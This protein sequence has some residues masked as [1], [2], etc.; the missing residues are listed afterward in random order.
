MTRGVPKKP[1]REEVD[2]HNVTHLPFRG[3]CETCVAGRGIDSAHRGRD[4]HEVAEEQRTPQVS[5]DWAFLRDST[6]SSLLNVLVGVDKRTRVNITIIAA[7]RTAAN[8]A[9]V[10][11]I[12]SNLRQLGHYGTLIIKTD[13]EPSLVELMTRVA[14]KREAGTILQ[15]SPPYDSQA[16]GLVERAVRSVEELTPVTKLDVERRLGVQISVQDPA[17]AWLLRHATHL[18]NWF[19]VGYDGRTPHHRLHG[20]PYKGE[21]VPL[22]SAVLFR[23]QTDIHGGL[24]QER[25]RS[26]TWL[27]KSVA[28][29]E[30]VLG[31][32][33]GR[34]RS[35]AD[36]SDC[37]MR[38]YGRKHCRESPIHPQ[39]L[40]RDTGRDSECEIYPLKCPTRQDK[41]C[42]GGKSLASC[43][44]STGQPQVVPSAMTGPR[45]GGPTRGIPQC[46]EPG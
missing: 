24:M 28:T 33:M 19:Q 40:A 5:F 16:N 43:F 1:A 17:F 25:W 20:R 39:R 38:E 41:G 8:D 31:P 10:T 14:A 7:D 21:L 23:H 11:E 36:R 9:T 45:T 32:L 22:F 44:T 27:G 4:P 37:G 34:G 6:G 13:G 15:R 18:L 2:K 12:V 35:E 46:A 30:H 3:W 42:G 29:G 26:G